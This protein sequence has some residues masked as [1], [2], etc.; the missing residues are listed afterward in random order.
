[1]GTA[2][3]LMVVAGGCIW[4]IWAKQID[5]FEDQHRYGGRK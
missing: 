4:G 5:D 1:L 2:L 3:L